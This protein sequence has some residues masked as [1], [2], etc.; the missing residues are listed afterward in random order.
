[1]SG[2][3]GTNTRPE[4]IVRQ[5]LHSQ[6]FRYRLHV[7]ELP[8]RPDLV[9]SRFRT[10]V[11]VHGCFWHQHKGCKYATMPATN[12]EF[13]SQKLQA[14]C[15][16]DMLNE[17][18]LRALGWKVLVIWECQIAADALGKLAS[19]ISGAGVDE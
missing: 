6:G 4:L 15:A 2:I 1:M 17:E 18:K 7:K 13:W 10:V 14:N 8:G 11:F 5:Y 16:R 3:K 12:P 19:S 9:F